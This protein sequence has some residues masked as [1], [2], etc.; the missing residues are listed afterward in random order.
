MKKLILC[1]F[2][3]VSTL[4]SA[5]WVK[6][7]E[8]GNNYRNDR[9]SMSV[10]FIAGN[11][12]DAEKVFFKVVEKDLNTLAHTDTF[13]LNQF[14]FKYI[15][16]NGDM[17]FLERQHNAIVYAVEVITEDRYNEVINSLYVLLQRR[18][19]GVEDKSFE[20]RNTF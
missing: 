19:R 14:C 11:R 15:D 2:L 7:D 9:L 20:L 1:L 6:N 3:I 10:V 17:Y 13:A 8:V 18:Q 5:D 4:L 12:D 16:E